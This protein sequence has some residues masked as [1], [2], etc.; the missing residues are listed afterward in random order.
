MTLQPDEVPFNADTI[1]RAV[2]Q[3][4][5]DAHDPVI[6]AARHAAWVAEEEALQREWNEWARDAWIARFG[7]PEEQK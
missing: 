4:R 3:L 2:E 6:R 7:G 1:R 5:T